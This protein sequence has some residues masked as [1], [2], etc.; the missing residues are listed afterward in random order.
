MARSR[1]RRPL[2]A[3]QSSAA[4]PLAEHSDGPGHKSWFLKRE[5]WFALIGISV[6]IG[7]AVVVYFVVTPGTSASQAAHTLRLASALISLAV[8]ILVTVLIVAI[9]TR[10]RVSDSE[11]RLRS[12]LPVH[13]Q[14]EFL[15]ASGLSAVARHA[16]LRDPL[17][18][19]LNSYE[20]AVQHHASPHLLSFASEGLTNL[21]DSMG[22]LPQKR[23]R[24]SVTSSFVMDTWR[25]RMSE[26]PVGTVAVAT[27]MVDNGWWRANRNW[28][29]YTCELMDTKD[30]VWLRIFLF[31]DAEHRESLVEEMQYQASRGIKVFEVMR[32]TLT[33]RDAA[34]K[35]FED[36]MLI[37]C[38]VE[39]LHGGFQATVTGGEALGSNLVNLDT[40]GRYELGGLQISENDEDLRGAA[41]RLSR[42]LQFSKPVDP[43][44]PGNFF[45]DRY[46]DIAAFKETEAE[47]EADFI[48]RQLAKHMPIDASHRVLDVA[49]AHGRIALRLATKGLEVVGIDA[50]APLVELA[51]AAAAKKGLQSVRF[52]HLDMADL[53]GRLGEFTCVASIFNSFGYFE[54]EEDNEDV[55]RA[56]RAALP[57]GGLLILDVDDEAYFLERRR[58]RSEPAPEA[59]RW[60]WGSRGTRVECRHSYDALSHRRRSRFF[61]GTNGTTKELPLVSVRL[62]DEPALRALVE[63][64]GFRVE[65]VFSS[66][67]D[68]SY[69]AGDT[70]HMIVVA[71]AT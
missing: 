8:V 4:L 17:Q 38:R 51:T 43:A 32:D 18:R 70:E 12:T 20:A 62:Y 41:E 40:G 50:C 59:S 35:T 7:L 57:Q 67:D 31:R 48:V 2:R 16:A 21:A 6:S 11:A 64:S 26:A 19:L 65:A 24:L 14:E 27:S 23:L 44:W 56:M 13:L 42:W 36:T 22:D 71:V 25:Q 5:P 30:F 33:G 54:T 10:E 46:P 39:N 37:G 69:R 15:R 34:L 47:V 28:L 60:N 9:S 55:L 45:D 1:I 29:D 58:G 52:E 68:R 49:C 61:V 66:F 63:R 53:N 3:P